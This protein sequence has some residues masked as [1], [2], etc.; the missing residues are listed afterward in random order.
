MLVGGTVAVLSSPALWIEFLRRAHKAHSVILTRQ[1]NLLRRSSRFG[2]SGGSGS[3]TFR[4]V[5]R[6]E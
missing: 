4:A 6:R 1:L 3:G 2:L 5:K